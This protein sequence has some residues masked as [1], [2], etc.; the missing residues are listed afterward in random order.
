MPRV[1]QLRHRIKLQSPVSTPDAEYGGAVPPSWADEDEVWA[2]IEPLRGRTYFAAAQANA[3]LTHKV[4]IRYR[5]GLLPSWR[6]L[7][8]ERALSIVSVINPEERN[9]WLELMCTEAA[10]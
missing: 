2:A 5:A 8:G 9:R 6:V 1:G 7:F 3:E 10:S 4:T